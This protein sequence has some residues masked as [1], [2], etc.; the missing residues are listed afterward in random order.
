MGMMV[1]FRSSVHEISMF[2]DDPLVVVWWGDY[3]RPD[4]LPYKGHYRRLSHANRRQKVSH[5][6]NSDGDNRL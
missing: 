5:Q 2:S 1:R 4:D 3:L 6:H